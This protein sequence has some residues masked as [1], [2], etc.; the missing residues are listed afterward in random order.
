[1]PALPDFT[2]PAE[3]ARAWAERYE[4]EQKALAQVAVMA[5]LAAV[6]EMACDQRHTLTRCVRSMPGVSDCPYH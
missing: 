2:N 3:T 5:P 6:G 1:M 4:G